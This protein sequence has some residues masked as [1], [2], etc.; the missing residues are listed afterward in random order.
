MALSEEENV[1]AYFNFDDGFLVEDC[2]D[3][4]KM[5]FFLDFDDLISE[6]GC[7]DVV[8]LLPKD[9]F[10]MN[11][12]MGMPYDPSLMDFN[13]SLPR[14]PFGMDF[15]IEATLAAINGWMEDF[16]LKA[17][18][19]QPYE[20]YGDCSDGYSNLKVD[21]D[22]KNDDYKFFAEL[23]F[24]WASS[25][26]DEFVDVSPVIYMEDGSYDDCTMI[27]GDMDDVMCFG[28]EKYGIEHKDESVAVD[29]IIFVLQHVNL[30]VTDLL[31][32]ERVCK[33]LRNAVQKDPYIWTSIHIGVPLSSKITDEDLLRLTD[34]A[35][36]KLRCL[37]LMKCLK[38]SKDGLKQVLERN[39]EL[40]KVLS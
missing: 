6:K 10:G 11:F 18:G 40:T 25:W 23:N 7:G 39:L 24:I 20:A 32:I 38:I 22:N 17:Y 14:D 33:S 5:R 4:E 34:R 1:F 9:P 27:E 15:N 21:Q 8:S 37:S 19:F 28:C 30:G 31:S 13:L 3:A 26:E 35:Q 36:G 12:N 2:Q 29:I 16:G